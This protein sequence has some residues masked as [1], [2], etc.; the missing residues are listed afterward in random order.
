MTT[1]EPKVGRR[2]IGTLSIDVK[3]ICDLLRTVKTD[4]VATYSDLSKLIGR[5]VRDNNSWILSS[6]RKR[7][8]SQDG[9]LFGTIPNVGL[10]RLRDADIIAA[11]RDELSRVH[12]GAL[13]GMRKIRAIQDYE[14]LSHEQ[15]VL[16][17]VTASALGIIAHVTKEKQL[18]RIQEKIEKSPTTLPLQRTLDAFRETSKD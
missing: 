4:E 17:G 5:S 9:I 6:A 15:K 11:S 7:L 3:T 2:A 8:L 18:A 16:H 1:Q 14:S 13:R 10:K 12:R